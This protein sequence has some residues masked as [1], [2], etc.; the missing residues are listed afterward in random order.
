MVAM[1]WRMEEGLLWDGVYIKPFIVLRCL[2]GFGG[3]VV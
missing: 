1:R 3:L 2:L